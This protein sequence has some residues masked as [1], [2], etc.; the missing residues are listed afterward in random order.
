MAEFK[1]EMVDN[2][3]PTEMLR[4]KGGEGFQYLYTKKYQ[5]FLKFVKFKAVRLNITRIQGVLIHLQ[6]VCNVSMSVIRTNK[7]QN[8]AL[9]MQGFDYLKFN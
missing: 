8:N 7:S 3:L 1:S 4:L 9:E 2:V 5:L 6:R